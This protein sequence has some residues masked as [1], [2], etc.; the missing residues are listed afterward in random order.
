MAVQNGLN[1]HRL[2]RRRKREN[3][4]DENEKTEKK[5]PTKS[6]SRKNK[7]QKEETTTEKNEPGNKM[8]RSTTELPEGT[9]QLENNN[10][11]TVL[12]RGDELIEDVAKKTKYV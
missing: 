7:Q 5:K 8:T 1:V 4:K 10:K 12:Q 3:E 9:M 11:Q 6:K 2:L